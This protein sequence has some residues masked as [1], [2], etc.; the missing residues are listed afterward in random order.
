MAV[1]ASLSPILAFQLPDSI[2]APDPH[3]Y[4]GVDPFTEVAYIL[5]CSKIIGVPIKD[6]AVTVDASTAPLELISPDAVICPPVGDSTCKLP[7]T[8]TA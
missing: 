6:P 3:L 8:F 5:S 7:D 2:P 1:G 4:S